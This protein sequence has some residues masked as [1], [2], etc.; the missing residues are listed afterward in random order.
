[1]SGGD[2]VSGAGLSSAE[3]YTPAVLTPPNLVSI[4]VTPANPT[5]SVGFTQR[6]IATGTFSDGSI[7]RLSSVTWS[8]PYPT[9]AGISNDV[10]NQGT[11]IA[12]GLG[13]STIT[14]SAGS[15]SGSTLLTVALFSISNVGVD[16]S[17]TSATL[18]WTTNEPGTSQVF[19]QVTR[20]PTWT[21]TPEDPTLVTSHSITVTGLLPNT[22][23]SL[24]A[25]STAQAGT[26][27]SPILNVRTL[28]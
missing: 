20:Q 13:T 15:V 4:A 12:V 14:A 5:L 1:M 17:S 3:L 23:Y 9:I 22:R 28:P 26:A 2:D 21:P 19:Y 11:A 7:Q 25:T 16:V 6:F 18:S 27:T 8:F 24:Y 10:S